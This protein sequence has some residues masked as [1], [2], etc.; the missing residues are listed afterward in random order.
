LITREQ[1]EQLLAQC[2]AHVFKRIW[3]SAHLSWEKKKTLSIGII[4]ELPSSPFEDLNQK[5]NNFNGKHLGGRPKGS[6]KIHS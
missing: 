3:Q 5:N 2:V 4:K 1:A 6:G